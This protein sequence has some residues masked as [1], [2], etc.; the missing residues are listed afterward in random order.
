M[1][2]QGKTTKKQSDKR[3]VFLREET[4]TV[5]RESHFL[6]LLAFFESIKLGISLLVG[7]SER[8]FLCLERLRFDQI[9]RFQPKNDSHTLNDLSIGSKTLLNLVYVSSPNMKSERKIK[10]TFVLQLCFSVNL[11]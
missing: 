6:R 7:V 5:N 8:L 10:K 3:Y 1:G 2:N 4:L 9:I 11:S